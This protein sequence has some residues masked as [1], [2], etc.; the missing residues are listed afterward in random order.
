MN[1]SSGRTIRT[2][3]PG[4]FQS[5]EEIIDQF[6]VRQRELGVVLDV[7][8]G[9]MDSASCQHVLVVAPRGQ[10]KTMLLARVAAELN[11]DDRFS[12]RLLPIRFM[13]ESHEIFDLA[14][15]WLETLFY[16]AQESAKRDPELAR[17]LQEAHA[18]LVKRWGEEALA[19][20]VRAT[21]LEAADLLGKKL[22]LMIENMQGLCENVDDDFGWQLRAALQSEPQ[23]MLLATATS[24]FAGLDD[25][26]QPFFELFHTLTLDPLDTAACR[27]LW[28][29][30]SGDNVN[31]REIR[32]LEILT[33]GNP[34][35]L[36]IVGGFAQHRSLSELMEELV[37]L[38]DEHTE[39]FRGHL[40]ALAKTE[41]R[42]YLAVIDLWRPSST[43]EIAERAR[44]DVR[45][46]SALLGRL[47][48][49][50]MVVIFEGD[51]RKRLYVAAERIYCLYY[52]LRRE[53]D[54]ADV[55]RELIQF[56]VVFYSE[57]EM[58]RIAKKWIAEANRFPKIRKGI[59]RAIDEEPDVGELFSGVAEPRVAYVAVP[60]TTDDNE[61]TER[62]FEE[63]S[64]LFETSRMYVETG[65]VTA[66]LAIYNQVIERFDDSYALE[67]QIYVA[68]ALSEKGY[69]YQELGDFHAALAA[70]DEVIERFGYI[71]IPKFQSLVARALSDKGYIF[72]H[73]FGD[74]MQALAA[75]DEL[76]MRFDDSDEMDIQ[77]LIAWSLYQK[78]NLKGWLED[79]M[80]AL[81]AYD[82][83]LV[84]FSGSESFDIQTWVAWVLF[85]KVDT[86]RQ[87]GDMA[88]AVAVCDEIIMRF[89]DSDAQE[90]QSP[91]VCALFEK[92]IR[93][94]EMGNKEKALR[95]RAEFVRRF[96]ALDYLWKVGCT[97]RAILMRPQAL[98]IQGHA[99][100]AADIL[101][102]VYMFLI[103][104]EK[105]II[106]RIQCIVLDMI[107]AGASAH[108][109]VDILSSDRIKARAL[110][111]LIVALR[112]H[113]GETVRYP[114]EVREVAADIRERI[115]KEKY[116]PK[117]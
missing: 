47:I 87:L 100:I 21:V 95:T 38:I 91:V 34:R 17:E 52:K 78:G 117:K 109:M 80:S 90:L 73:P 106:D 45:T 24:R 11:V 4:T 77:E 61:C 53:R 25:A 105:V 16:L 57:E 14:D 113:A 43:G 94:L 22:V 49:R 12:G 99:D 50:G 15:F 102:F 107:A 41:R 9:N 66:A 32:P 58:A 60:D 115:A 56:M 29:V 108:E 85:E 65:D 3:N 68:W 19:D 7:L 48:D 2:F 10:G 44:M 71:D 20:R 104:T 110:R 74:T 97:F 75:Y 72:A 69:A 40:E 83:M 62:L 51:N 70:Y 35:L 84:R 116:G 46:V 101:R 26:N 36:V 59:E 81:D 111:P 37:Q 64:A 92:G 23:I 33:G 103:P 6:V 13:E 28:K 55:V 79:Y 8:R 88:S 82:E 5:D 39:Y 96:Q 93:Q 42:V 27:R 76:L 1:Q 54:E 89:G 67:F 30:V 98:P 31:E 18:D 86:Q 63:M 112:Q 114:I